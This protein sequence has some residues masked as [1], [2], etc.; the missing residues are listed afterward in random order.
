MKTVGEAL[1]TEREKKSLDIE[2]VADAL[3]IRAKYL[4]AL[5]EGNYTIF[6][7]PLYIKGFLKNYAK[8]LGLD[9]NELMALY[10]REY[11]FKAY[12][13]KHDIFKHDPSIKT[14]KFSLRPGHIVTIL[15]ILVVAFIAFYLFYEYRV[16]SAPPSL[17][18]TAP[19]NNEVV[20]VPT[21]MVSGITTA[22]DKVTINGVQVQSITSD[23]DFSTDVTLQTGINTLVI[24]STNTLNRSATDRVQVI[25]ENE[26]INAQPTKSSQTSA[27]HAKV[28]IA[29]QG[30]WVKITA[31]NKNVYTGVLQPGASESFTAASYVDIITGNAQ[32]T[33][34]SIN[35][36]VVPIQG[37]GDVEKVVNINADGSFN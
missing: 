3:K 35:G 29:N 27:A 28:V 9:E 7:S 32:D 16:F 31:D 37:S 30:T 5:E 23:G 6:A 18:V 13:S 14:I 2:F 22:G 24:V 15:T 8:F 10:R 20:N 17:S 21:L 34:L 26:P 12:D 36:T 19:T 1:R 25:Y 33:T 4:I 11:D